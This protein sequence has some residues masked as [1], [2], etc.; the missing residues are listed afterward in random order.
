VF[1]AGNPLVADELSKGSQKAI[2]RLKTLDELSTMVRAKP[3]VAPK[4]ERALGEMINLY[5]SY[6]TEKDNYDQFGG[7]KTYIDSIKADTLLKMQKL[8]QFNENTKAAYDTIFGT[9]L[10]D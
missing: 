4:T 5:Q 9:L 10:G 1:F 6:K 3:G 8:A 2:D 7:N